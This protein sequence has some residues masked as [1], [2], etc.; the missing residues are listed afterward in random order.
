M[1]RDKALLEHASQSSF[2]LVTELVLHLN[3]KLG[4]Q[5]GI[6]RVRGLQACECCLD[7][8]LSVTPIRD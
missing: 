5:G 4:K 2:G 8:L 1:F 3:L 7:P 6:E